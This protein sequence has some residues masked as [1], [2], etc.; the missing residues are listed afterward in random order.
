[1]ESLSLSRLCWLYARVGNLTFGGGD[2]TMAALQAETVMARG[3]LSREQY[4]LV[5]GLARVTPG[6]NILAFC[7]GS[8]WR[9]LGWPGAIG[10]VLA[11]SLPSSLV[12]VW[13]THAY[14]SLRSNALAMAAVDGT[15]AAAAGMM[16]AGAWQ[17]L[18]P[19][20]TKRRWLRTT[21]LYGASLAL[22]L[23]FSVPP[24]PLLGAAFALGLAWEK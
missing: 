13:F 22:T 7:A 4:A 20:L 24:V 15:L 6:T 17:L 9:M 21:L 10:G 2:P 23:G 11:V 16:A 3:W 1:M 8:A 5:Y 19:H 12:V 18:R 14:Q